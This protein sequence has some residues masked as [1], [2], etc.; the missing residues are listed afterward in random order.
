MAD[1]DAG[2][3]TVGTSL[4][5][6][7]FLLGGLFGRG[8][9][10]GEALDDAVEDFG[11]GETREGERGDGVRLFAG[12]KQADDV[13]GKGEGLACAGGGADEEVGFFGHGKAP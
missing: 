8:G 9:G 5:D 2:E 10:R 7:G 12:E 4:Y 1:A 11:G 6:V 3:N 13:R